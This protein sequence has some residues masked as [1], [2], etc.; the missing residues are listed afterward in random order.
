MATRL[1]T[2][3]AELLTGEAELRVQN[4]REE[5]KRQRDSLSQL[6]GNVERSRAELVAPDL[7]PEMDLGVEDALIVALE[8]RLDVARARD[9]L[10]DAARGQ[11]IAR[12]NELPDLALTVEVE[13]LDPG[14]D[15][16]D[17]GWSGDRWFV[18]LSLQPDLTPVE[19]RAGVAQADNLK[20]RLELSWEQLRHDVRNEVRQALRNERR[21]REE[22]DQARR[23]LELA[24]KRL[25]LA[26]ARFRL[27]QVDFE[28]VSD[29]EEALVRAETE[30]LT[31]RLNASVAG[32]ELR[33]VL[34]TL[35]E[36]PD[37]LAP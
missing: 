6:L 7:I 21:T 2:L 1:D 9:Q 16:G 13:P 3:R 28:S 20:K 12:R 5:M 17:W 37:E 4:S 30:V 8:N 18:G 27:G 14:T 23:N 26:S 32:Y 29:A 34:G 22:Y 24:D 25:R 36:P 11:E 19:E 33:S 35:V 15:N 10:E 31:S